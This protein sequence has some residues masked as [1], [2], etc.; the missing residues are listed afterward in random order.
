MNRFKFV[1][2]AEFIGNDGSVRFAGAIDILLEE[3]P[4]MVQKILSDNDILF[5]WANPLLK[6]HRP[7]SELLDNLKAL[8][9]SETLSSKL[10]SMTDFS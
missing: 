10:N 2:T 4:D 7:I 1:Q 3:K 9:N 8:N 6:N 5:L